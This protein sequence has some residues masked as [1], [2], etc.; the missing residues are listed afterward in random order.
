[1]ESPTTPKNGQ[2]GAARPTRVET[3]QPYPGL[4]SAQEV[5]RTVATPPPE[6]VVAA[7]RAQKAKA[8]KPGK[9]LNSIL[10]N[11]YKTMGFAILTVILLGLV[12]FLATNLFYFVSTSWVTPTVIAPTDERVLALDARLAEQ[13]SQR[14]KL[15]AERAL[16]AASLADVERIIAVDESFQQSFR[17]AVGADAAG[18]KAELKKLRALAGDYEQAKAEN[19]RSN[20]AYAGMSR[21][22]NEQLKEAQLIDQDEYV[23]GNY[24][25]SQIAHAN[26]QLAEKAVELDTKASELSRQADG[27]DATARGGAR[28][29]ALS[30][31]V[32]RIRQ[33]LQ[34]ATLEL[35]KARDTRRALAESLRAADR[36]IARYDHI[37]QSIE[38]SPLVRAAAG[39]M[40]L[41]LVPY[42]NLSSVKKGAPLY[43]CALGFVMCRKVGVVA[44]LLPGEMEVR[45]P[46]HASKQLRGQAVR[47]EL[48]APRAAEQAVLFA[49]GAPLLL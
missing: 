44:E 32:L 2:I 27:L 1:M 35:Q 5:D 23:T 22:R 43:S 34:R 8:A 13:S 6:H 11:A 7:A 14:D 25:L 26:L 28:S 36:S 46:V 48:T 38:Q 20:R 33:E 30:Y 4:T 9:P 21:E 18:R 19:G 47:L 40:T 3:T 10:V 24:Q 45:H 16:V 49:G 39:R 42:D 29:E 15:A 12:S 31:D 41:A 17:R 37:V